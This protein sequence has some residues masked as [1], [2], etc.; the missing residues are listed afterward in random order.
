MDTKLPV[1]YSFRRCPYAIRARMAIAESLQ[2]VELRE[3]DLKHKPQELLDIS[4]KATVPV[5]QLSHGEIFEESIDIMFWALNADDPKNWLL[6]AE[7]QL[8]KELI[9]TNDNEF[10]HYLDRYKYADR[11]PE[12]P[13]AYYRE[14]ASVFPARLDVLL[15]NKGFLMSEKAS[16]VDIAVFPFIRQFAFVDKHWF[17]SMPWRY[18]Q[19]WLKYFLESALFES[20]MKK[21]LPWKAGDDP[22]IFP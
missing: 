14:Q 8:T 3:V 15:E 5:L 2:Q 17:D 1:L 4:P 21:Q 10:K 11:F 16:M 20:V 18:L 19:G 22:V 7:G 6:D 13:V 12:N 9:K